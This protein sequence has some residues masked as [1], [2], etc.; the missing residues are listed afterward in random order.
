MS[1][2]QLKLHDML[3][4]QLE[5][6]SIIEDDPER[7]KHEIARSAAMSNVGRLVIENARLSLDAEKHVAE[8]GSI[9]L[10]AML[11]RDA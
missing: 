6:L 8:H 9:R 4:E 11:K 1:N 3:F 5:R 2:N 10:P 7:L